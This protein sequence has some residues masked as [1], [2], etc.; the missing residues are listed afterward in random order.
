MMVRSLP[1]VASTV[2]VH[3]G[4]KILVRLGI[5]STKEYFY[6]KWMHDEDF[7]KA[8]NEERERMQGNAQ[9]RVLQT[10]LA[11]E[12]HITQELLRIALSKNHPQKMRAIEDCYAL[13][14][15][16][17]MAKGSKLNVQVSAA[18]AAKQGT[19]ADRLERLVLDRNEQLRQLGIGGA[20][21]DTEPS[22]N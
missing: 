17:E 3:N 2:T 8:L 12:T 4:V 19:F 14:K 6:R 21:P 5:I 10:L 1:I 18:I 7:K 22:D 13:M 20:G 15:F 16:P 9:E 11:H